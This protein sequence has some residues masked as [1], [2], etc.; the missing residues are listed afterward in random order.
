MVQQRDAHFERRRHAGA[1]HFGQNITGQVSLEIRI[2]NSGQWILTT[3][4]CHVSLE[5]F[6]SV[7]PL[8]LG[9]QRGTE[10]SAALLVG[11]NRDRGEV[12]SSVSRASSS[13]VA[14][15]RSGRGAQSSFG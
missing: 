15:A 8:Q 13:R 9:G 14:L 4:S 11:A 6:D 2:L 3:G 10:Q 1:I 5:H 7:V 12:R